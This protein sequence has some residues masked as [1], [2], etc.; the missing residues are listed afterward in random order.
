MT[1]DV[2]NAIVNGYEDI[3]KALVTIVKRTGSAP[4]D[5]GT[6]ML[7]LAD[8]RIVGTIGGGCV[9]AEIRQKAL[10]V[11]DTGKATIHTIVLTA[12]HAEEEGMVCGGKVEVFIENIK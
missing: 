9:E 6:K 5:V 3:P 12:N 4:R 1:K 7:V 11:I 10:E 2:I 8:G